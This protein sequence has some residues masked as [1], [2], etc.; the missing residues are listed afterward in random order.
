[1][2]EYQI[3]SIDQIKQALKEDQIDWQKEEII[4]LDLTDALHNLNDHDQVLLMEQLFH[5]THQLGLFYY[6][7]LPKQWLEHPHLAYLVIQNIEDKKEIDQFYKKSKKEHSPSLFYYHRVENLEQIKNLRPSLQNDHEHIINPYGLDMNE[8]H[9]LEFKNLFQRLLQS[10]HRPNIIFSLSGPQWIDWH[11]ATDNIFGGPLIVDLDLSNSCSHSCVFCSLYSPQIETDQSSLSSSKDL[12]TFKSLKMDKTS[13]EAFLQSRF[14]LIQE[15]KLAG[16]GEPTTHPLFM[17]TLKTLRQRNYKVVICSHLGLW[18]K[19]HVDEIWPYL[20]RED[21]T[22]EFFVNLSGA[23][24]QTYTKTR[25]RQTSNDFHKIIEVMK[26]S[27]EKAKK[28]GKAIHYTILCIL[29]DHNYHELPLY[30]ALA[31][32]VGAKNLW[33]KAMEIHHPQIKDH[34]IKNK[35]EYAVALKMLL[36]FADEMEVS[37]QS[38]RFINGQIQLYRKELQSALNDRSW[39]IRL[40]E[41]LSQYP[42]LLKHFINSSPN[43]E[44]YQKKK[45][46]LF[47]QHP[48]PFFDSH[49]FG[50]PLFEEIELLDIDKVV[51]M[52]IENSDFPSKLYTKIPCYTPSYYLRITTRNQTHPCCLMPDSTG[53]T[54]SQSLKDIWFSTESRNVREKLLSINLEHFHLNDSKWSFCQQCPHT[55]LNAFIYQKKFSLNRDNS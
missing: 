42:L 7:T 50:H 15:V 11:I 53:E 10:T 20:N 30:A 47:G 29:N 33:P 6:P 13:L 5:L 1:M 14:H 34:Q 40:K 2:R 3:L 12:N 27:F 26:Y 9:I 23:T 38:Y 32:E 45:P 19:E 44:S 52:N 43:Y 21:D 31:K 51:D 18:K 28:E 37:L 39:N 16:V 55:H 25:P 35:F 48:R 36:Y 22:L 41:T 24:E 8:A 17:Q 46:V 4:L 54:T 49:D